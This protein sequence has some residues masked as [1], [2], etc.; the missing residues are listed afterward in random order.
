MTFKGNYLQSRD[1]NLEDILYGKIKVLSDTAWKDKWDSSNDHY[2][3]W[4]ENFEE[5]ERIHAMYMLSKF[6]YFDND[7]IRELMRRVY[8]DLY[9]RPI[10]Y[11]IRRNIKSIDSVKIET[12]YESVLC[13]TRFMSLG[14]PSESSAHLLY[15]FRQENELPS[16]LF[17]NIHELLHYDNERK[18]FGVNNNEGIE[19]IVII[20][21]FCGSGTQAKEFNDKFLAF[22][23]DNILGLK[24]YYFSLFAIQTGLKSL[25]NLFYDGVR[26]IFILDESYKCFSPISRF[27]ANQQDDF[28]A[29][30][31]TICRKYGKRLATTNPLGYK[32]C[33]MLLGFHHNTPNNT[34]PIFWSDKEGWEPIFKRFKKKY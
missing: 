3:K 8:E 1:N 16:N 23:K 30:C 11:D 25:E 6:M 19:R 18:V 24:V 31:K 17:I 34:L 15:Y 22:L 20:D 32:N 26:S 28:K 9:R 29:A 27:F 13:R 10:I 33:Q 12:E 2:A 21:D 7:S 5:E 4:I 14:N